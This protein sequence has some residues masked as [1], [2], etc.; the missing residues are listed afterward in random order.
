MRIALLYLTYNSILFT[1]NIKNFNI[2]IHPKIPD[3][4][5]KN[6]KKY[7]IK[8]LVNTKWADISIIQATLNLLKESIND[9]DW[10][11]LLSEDSYPIY[12]YDNFIKIFSKI[13]NKSIFDLIENKNNYWKTSQFWIL[14]KIDANIILN[15][16]QLDKFNKINAPDEYYFLS[17]LKWN[18]PN[19]S[20]LN[21]K[22]MYT[23]WLKDVIVKSP[24]TFNKLTK[25]DLI[26][27]K[28]YKS[29]FIRKVLPTFSFELYKPNKKLYVIYIGTKTKHNFDLL[30]NNDLIDIILISAINK[31]LINIKLLNK[32]IYYIPIIYKFYYESILS[33]Y[34]NIN[35]SYWNIIIFTTEKF[36]LEFNNITIDK[37]KKLLPI[38]NKYNKSIFY[39]IT[40]NNNQ[41]AFC[42][43]Q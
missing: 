27:I 33:I 8:N 35:L 40:D 6:Y 37:Q 41:L 23:K 32:C 34:N 20:F 18:N 7:I 3:K 4:V 31:S 19:Y 16:I 36:N 29:L 2:Y 14:N 42:I 30:I 26:D 10:F 38:N 9:N 28:K 21:M 22:I 17:I 11:I 15:N 13:N 1:E 5:N 24:I 25:T 12:D 39:Y 43:K